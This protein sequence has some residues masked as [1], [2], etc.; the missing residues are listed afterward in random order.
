MLYNIFLLPIYFIHSGYCFLILHLCLVPPSSLPSG[1]NQNVL[2]ESVLLYTFH[3]FI[4]VIS[5]TSDNIDYLVF[6]LIY[7]TKHSIL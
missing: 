6:C 2:C 4:L 3:C 7:F 5:H 1:N